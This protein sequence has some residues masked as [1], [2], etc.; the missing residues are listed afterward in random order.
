[1]YR[2]CIKCGKRISM[3]SNDPMEIGDAVM[4]YGC[5]K[6]IA[7]DINDLYYLKSSKEFEEAKTK[8]LKK[9]EQFYSSEVINCLAKE[10]DDIYN[11]IKHE[12]KEKAQ[13]NSEVSLKINE[14]VFGGLYENIGKKI[15]GFAKGVFV[16]ET[17]IAILGGIAACANGL[18]S[19][20][21]IAM[22]IGPIVAWVSS[23]MLYALGE[24]VDKTAMNER[25][26]HNI[27]ELMKKN[28]K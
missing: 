4:C 2:I 8:I 6:P 13:N 20:G 9:S 22:F 14:E 26:T 19:L 28:M 24:L 3:F 11:D 18:V 5:A 16:V 7:N 25:N 1:M 17:L 21:V 23:W 15:K 27:L 10:I 12:F